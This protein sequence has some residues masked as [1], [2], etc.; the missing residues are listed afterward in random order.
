MRASRCRILPAVAGT[1][2]DKTARRAGARHRA[3]GHRLWHAPAVGLFGGRDLLSRP[4]QGPVGAASG[5]AGPPRLGR[6]LP[7]GA[8]LGLRLLR[9]A[10]RE[11]QRLCGAHVLAGHG[12]GRGSG[13]RCGGRGADRPARRGCTG[14]PDRVPAAPGRRDGTAQPHH[15]ADPQGRRHANSW[16]HRRQRRRSSGRGASTS[17]TESDL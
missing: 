16:R 6:R 12:T 3:R 1:P 4:G 2:P 8:Q 7:A 17:T 5:Q 9:D 10:G 13:D 15:H 14:R 11:R